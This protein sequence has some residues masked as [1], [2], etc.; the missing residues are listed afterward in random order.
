VVALL[1]AGGRGFGDYTGAVRTRQ[2]KAAGPAAPKNHRFWRAGWSRAP[3]RH[4]ERTARMP[5]RSE[6]STEPQQPKAAGCRAPKNHGCRR[7]GGA[8][9]P[10]A[11]DRRARNG[12]EQPSTE[13]AATQS[14]RMPPPKNHRSV[15]AGGAGAPAGTPRAATARMAGSGAINGAAPVGRGHCAEEQGHIRDRVTEQLRARLVVAP[16]VAGRHRG[17]RRRRG[18]R[19]RHRQY[20]GSMPRQ[21]RRITSDG[22]PRHDWCKSRLARRFQRRSARLGSIGTS[23]R[24]VVVP[25]IDGAGPEVGRV[26]RR[27][28][29]S[30]RG[31]HPEPSFRT[32]AQPTRTG[33]APGPPPITMFWVEVPLHQRVYTKT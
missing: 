33:T 22:M 3:R 4:R 26:T 8:G 29:A 20:D 10:P 31:A 2:P 7:A 12:R 24:G 19:L 5:P 28:T 15:R 27:C 13:P 1:E 30:T 32:D 17:G 21:P 6:P 14:G 25:V 16:A 11:R 23:A 18:R 9:A